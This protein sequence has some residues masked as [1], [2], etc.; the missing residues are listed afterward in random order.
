MKYVLDTNVY[1]GAVPSEEKR[2]LFRQTFFPLI[3]ATYLSAVVAYELA[4]SAQDRRTQTLVREFIRPM[5]RDGPRGYADVQ[6]LDDHLRSHHC[7][8]RE[9]A[10][11]AVRAARIAQRCADR[12]LRSPDRRHPARRLVGN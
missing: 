10:W 12:S 2:V 6:R 3:P 11:V 7:D 5:E 1:L 8:R 9:R 4:V